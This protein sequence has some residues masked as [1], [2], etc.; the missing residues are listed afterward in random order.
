MMKPLRV[1]M[2]AWD[3][4][5]EQLLREVIERGGHHLTILNPWKKE[6]AFLDEAKSG[7]Y[8][9]VIL[10]NTIPLDFSLRLIAPL[11][12]ACSTK[13]IVM[14]WGA[15]EICREAALRAGADAFYALPISGEQILEAVEAATG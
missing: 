13:V 14:S 2:A 12:G 10:T 11:R 9:V 1:L 7:G 3:E 8:D 5:F 4:L 15:D 6:Q